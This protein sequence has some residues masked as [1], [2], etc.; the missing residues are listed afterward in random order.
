MSYF[1]I[2]QTLARGQLSTWPRDTAAVRIVN[3]REQ[4]NIGMFYSTTD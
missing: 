3:C 2:P 1:N 4:Q